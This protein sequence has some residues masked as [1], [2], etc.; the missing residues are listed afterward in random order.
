MKLLS[1]FKG[2]HI[3]INKLIKKWDNLQ[4]H[5]NKYKRYMD[6]TSR[7]GDPW[8]LHPKDLKKVGLPLCLNKVMYDE[9][10]EWCGKSRKFQENVHTMDT[11]KKHVDAI[12]VN[13]EETSRGETNEGN[14]KSKLKLKIETINV[15]EDSSRWK[16]KIK[17]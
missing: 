17:R 2:I 11:L 5:Y 3:T 14:D 16:K 6:H 1:I 7:G 12:D 8:Q 10:N 9:M 15:G 13:D 4:K